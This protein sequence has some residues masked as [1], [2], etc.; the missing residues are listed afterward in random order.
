MRSRIP[1]LITLIALLLLG[2]IVFWGLSR[3]FSQFVADLPAGLEDQ[4]KASL[5]REVSIRSARFTAP[6][7]VVVTGLSIAQGK[8]FAEGTLFSARRV[9]V[10]FDAFNLL[11]GRST[12]VRSVRKVT[13]EDPRLRL[14]RTRELVWNIEDL[15][16]RPPTPAE[17]RF[18]GLVRI[19][20]GLITLEDYGANLRDLPAINRIASIDGTIDLAPRKSARVKLSGTGLRQRVRRIEATGRLGIDAP[21]SNLTLSVQGADAGYW[22]DY[23]SDVPSWSLR[24]GILNGRAVIYQ[25]PTGKFTARGAATIRSAS[26]ASRYLSVPIRQIAANIAF[27]GGNIGIGARGLLGGS[28]V[29]ARGH[30]LGSRTLNLRV[31][32]DR[33]DLASLQRAIRALPVVPRARWPSPATLTASVTGPAENPRVEAVMS[34]PR[35]AVYGVPV[36]NLTARGTYS[37]HVIRILDL[38]AGIAGGTARL[39]GTV[40]VPSGRTTV[41]GRASGIRLGAIPAPNGARLVGT[42]DARF[43]LAWFRGLRSTRITVDVTRGRIAALT[44]ASGTA[45]VVFTGPRVGRASLRIAQGSAAGLPFESATLGLTLRGNTIRVRRAVVEAFEGAITASGTATT[46]GRLDLELTARRIA[47]QALLAPLGYGH[48]TGTASFDGRLTGAIGFPRISGV[49]AA[50]DG[51]LR[52]AE[53]ELMTAH[54]VATPT[55]LVLADPAIKREQA[56]VVMAGAITIAAG[57]APQVELRIRAREVDLADL[58]PLLGLPI[59][60]VGTTSADVEVRGRLP[61]LVAE[62]EIVVA[63][64]RIAGVPVDIAQL[65]LRLTDGRVVISRLLARR[66]DMRMA[67][68]GFVGPRGRIELSLSSENLTLSLL[69]TI[70]YPYVTLRGPMEFSGSVSGTLS[71]PVVRATLVSGAPVLNGQRFDLLATDLSWDGVRLVLTDTSLLGAAARYELPTFRFNPSAGFIELQARVT[72]AGIE[73]VVGLLGN[74]PIL[75]TPGGQAI[76]NALRTLPEQFTGSLSA[77]LD[78]VGPLKNLTGSAGTTGTN[79]VLGPTRITKLEAS[80]VAQ[81]SAF[82]LDKMVLMAPDVSLTATA[83]FVQAKPVEFAATIAE[84]RLDALLR[85]IEN[86]PFLPMFEFGRD[87]IAAVQ[88]IPRPVKGT[89]TTTLSLTDIQT[90]ATG[91]ASFTAADVA[92]ADQPIGTIRADARF[93]EGTMFIDRLALAGPEAAASFKGSVSPRG[94]LSLTGRAERVPLAALQPWV[95]APDLSGSLT[96]DIRATGP[97]QSPLMEA[98]IVASNVRTRRF[99]FDAIIVER[100]IIA[101]GRISTENLVATSNA[102][103]LIV[104]GSLPFVWRPPFIPT[105]QPILI[106]AEVPGQDLSALASST[107]A[108]EQAGGKLAMTLEITGTLEDPALNGRLTVEDGFLNMERFENDFVNLQVE[109]VFQD[110]L[111]MVNRFTGASSLGGTFSIAGNVAFPGLS[112]PLLTLFT[113]VDSLELSASNLTGILGERFNLVATG[114]LTVSE[115]LD[116]PL[117]QGQ[118]VGRDARL[119]IPESPLPTLVPRARRVFNPR[120]RVTVNLAADVEIERGPL[121]VEVVGPFAI[122]GSLGDPSIVGTV[123]LSKGRLRYPGRTLE[124]VPGGSATFVFE[125]PEEARISVNVRARTRVTAPS[126]ITGRLTRYTINL[127]IAGPLGD[128]DINVF[129]SPPGL[130]ETAA[131]ALVFRQARVEALLRGEPFGEIIQRQLAETLIGAAFPDIFEGFEFAGITL[132]IEPGFEIPIQFSASTPLTGR[133]SIAYTRSVIGRIPFDTLDLS[134]LLRPRLAFTTSFEDN[135]EVLYLIEGATRF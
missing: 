45:E 35:A 50:R 92:L 86:A 44:F 14:I 29:V 80:F 21:I 87:L 3:R 41:A 49:I 42:A 15:L 77:S 120:F 4:L 48:L 12:L 95:G 83:R 73:N 47:L 36:A 116:S 52:Q 70:L 94:L 90:G 118:L 72:S 115:T 54:I 24:R 61:N 107:H 135:E 88:T 129:S 58:F 63:D 81:R 2:L 101:G 28:S 134:Y 106:R 122:R 39:S 121:R 104:S 126:A 30:I 78:L 23:F 103:R 38:R 31:T 18:R 46:T 100:L 40:Q 105:D 33:I 55:S 71:R 69:D 32:S 11:T 114:Q 66:G 85:L 113:W 98:S 131:L 102:S 82:R 124:L 34:V 43:S 74:S 20:S 132:A 26:I 125:P 119:E 65:S 53:Y 84:S 76:L 112:T 75:G 7:R 64:A 110:S 5:N 79:I 89:L 10:E 59:E 67:G 96:M 93:V 127:D 13:L 123:A 16:R 17:E 60:A 130:T 1:L 6:G 37:N 27:I 108:V 91:T 51:Q 9:I 117:I 19:Q 22:L 99:D 109:A 133:L 57:G 62:G 56:E 97:I 128:L 8:T 68:E 25:K 111:L